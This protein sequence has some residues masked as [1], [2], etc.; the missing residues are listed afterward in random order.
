MAY[1]ANGQPAH[2]VQVDIIADCGM[3]TTG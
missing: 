3:E 2:G 1:G